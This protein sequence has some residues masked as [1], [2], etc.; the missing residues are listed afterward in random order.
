[1]LLVLSSKPLTCYV[2]STLIIYCIYVY[3][4]GIYRATLRHCKC[5]KIRPPAWHFSVLKKPSAAGFPSHL[6]SGTLF[7]QNGTVRLYYINAN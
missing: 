1:M 5:S 3:A 7:L 6:S 2:Y 4:A